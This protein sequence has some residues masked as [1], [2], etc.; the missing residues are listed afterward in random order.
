MSGHVALYLRI[1]IDRGGR[2]EGVD[3]QERQGRAYAASTWPGIPVVAYSDNDLSAASDDVWRPAFEK[4]RQAVRDGQVTRIWA[5]EQSRLQRRE[6]GWFEL[7]AELTAAGITEVHTSPATASS[8]SATKS[9]GSRP[10][11]PPGRSGK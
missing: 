5:V 1:S 3:V 10:C 11:S 2:A 6:V 8:A 9:P 4:L 7:A